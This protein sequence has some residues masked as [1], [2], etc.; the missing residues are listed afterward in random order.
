LWAELRVEDG[1]YV[2]SGLHLYDGD[3]VLRYIL[4]KRLVHKEI[5][6]FAPSDG[7]ITNLT[8]S[9]SVRT[10][11]VVV[12]PRVST[13]PKVRDRKLVMRCLPVS[14]QGACTCVGS[15]ASAAK[16][17]WCVKSHPENKNV[18]QKKGNDIVWDD[19]L[20]H[21]PELIFALA[22]ALQNLWYSH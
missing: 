14:A 20:Q 8:K 17:D 9:L 4:I 12:S 11:G 10:N 6:I 13:A 16:R 18:L 21:Q 15:T 3:R 5:R 19:R 2:H 1:H 22:V 7:A